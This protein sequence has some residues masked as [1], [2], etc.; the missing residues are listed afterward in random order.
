VAAADGQAAAPAFAV[1]RLVQDFTQRGME[2]GKHKRVLAEAL[3]WVSA[4][5][6]GSP[7]D[8]RSWATLDPLAPHALALARR[9][10]EAGI[11]DPPTRL[12][13]ELGSL[14][15]AKS[16]Y[17]EAEPLYRRALAIDEAW[18]GPD[19]PNVAIRLNNLA[20]IAQA[21]D[22]LAEAEAFDTP[23]ARDRRGELQADHPEVA[24]DLN[25]LA[26]LLKA[27]NRLMMSSP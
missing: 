9:A 10:D 7:L 26:Q 11:P 14:F 5:F 3:E 16:R 20:S 2:E 6:V 4:G 22:R 21:T 12:M 18:Y 23:R 8:V 13:N 17:A 27:T 19:H 25:N 24:I 1:H 15:Y